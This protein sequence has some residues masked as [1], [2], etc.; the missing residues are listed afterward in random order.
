M[1]V[2]WCAV[3]LLILFTD[4]LTLFFELV[5]NP[6]KKWAE[7]RTHHLGICTA[8]HLGCW[9]PAI[10]HNMRCDIAKAACH[11]V[12][13]NLGHFKALAHTLQNKQVSID[14][15]LVNTGAVNAETFFP[16][17]SM[18]FLSLQNVF[19]LK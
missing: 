9:D 14:T 6:K 13:H 7:K 16:G 5:V 19:Q 3:F 1:Q 8:S 2:S 11:Q 17:Y 18:L 4:Y 15:I 10:A 12:A